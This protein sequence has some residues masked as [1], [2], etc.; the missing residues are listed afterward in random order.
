MNIAELA[1]AVI[2]S[3]ITLPLYLHSSSAGFES[4]VEDDDP[5]IDLNQHLVRRPAS[6]FYARARGESMRD[7]GIFDGDLLIVDRSLHP[8]HG[9]LVVAALDGEL[10]CRV[11]D[12]RNSQLLSADEESPALSLSDSADL[13]IE[14]VVVSAIKEFR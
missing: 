4:P 1:P 5:G 11:L 9:D 14:G 8:A 10:L 13:R 2:H 6:T 7:K 12:L 3:Q